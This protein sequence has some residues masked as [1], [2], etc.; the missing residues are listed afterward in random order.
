[1]R[2]LFI[3]LQ[4]IGFSA[5]AQHTG[6][7]YVLYNETGK[8]E[9][10][11]LTVTHDAD[12][13]DG[14]TYVVSHQKKDTLY[15]IGSYLNGHVAL[16]NDG[17]TV[18]H[19]V[20][21]NASKPLNESVITFY[22]DGKV[23]DS[24]KLAKLI[25]YELKE[26]I[27]L[28]RLP[29]SGWLKNDSLLHKMATNPFYITDDRLFISFDDPILMVFDMNQ[30]FHI[31]TGN[32]ANHFMQN[33]YSIP[34]A[35]RRA[36]MIEEAYFPK[37][38][39]TTEDGQNLGKLIET[40]SGKKLTEKRPGSNVV[41]ITFLLSDTGVAKVQKLEA[42]NAKGE[43]EHE[44]EERIRKSIETPKFSTNPIPPQHPAWLFEAA[45]F[46]K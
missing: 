29:K 36:E 45:F 7:S 39:P 31:F 43:H 41:E 30:M 15:S 34:N 23:F 11:S 16:S 38:L 18:A 42:E 6:N 5:V 21:E 40:A 8:F 13:K 25:S 27:A 22:R 9:L 32:G 46:L 20:S 24:V 33:Y 26:T 3:I 12:N 19:L 37:D 4:A 14:T 17:R 10:V 28:N 35:P 44:L 2:H 1:M